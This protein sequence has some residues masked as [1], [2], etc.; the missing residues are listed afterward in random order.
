[1]VEWTDKQQES[2]KRFKKVLTEA[3]VLIQPE[4]GKEFIIESGKTSD[5]GLNSEG[6][7]CFWGRV[8]IPKDTD[9]RQSILQ[10]AHSS[11]YAI[12]LGGNKMYRDV[13]EE[14]VTMDF[15]SCLPLMPTKKDSVWVDV[16]QLAKS[17]HFILVRTYYSLQKLAKLYVSEIVLLHRVPIFIISD[18]DPHFMSRF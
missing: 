4:P 18:K 2:F 13:R 10:E 15:V 6:V 9:L 7:L 3:P 5:F 17:A 16:D 1:M 12:H 11:P 14:R 8:C